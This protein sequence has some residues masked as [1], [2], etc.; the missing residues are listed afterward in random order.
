MVMDRS[1]K[2]WKRWKDKRE[3]KEVWYSEQMYKPAQ[4][5]TKRRLGNHIGSP[6]RMKG[7]IKVQKKTSVRKESSSGGSLAGNRAKVIQCH[8]LIEAKG[9]PLR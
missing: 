3:Q 8:E 4:S 6:S 2:N 1:E 5:Y 7:R 9:L